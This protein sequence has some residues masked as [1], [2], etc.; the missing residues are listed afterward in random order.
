MLI[1]STVQ[2]NIACRN[3]PMLPK[4]CL[5][6]CPLLDE[7]WLLFEQNNESN[8]RNLV[9]S[10][11][12]G[13]AKVMSY[14]DI[15]EAQAKVIRGGYHAERKIWSEAQKLCACAG[16]GQKGRGK[17]RWKLP[18]MKLQQGGWKLLP[19][20]PCLIPFNSDQSPVIYQ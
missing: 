12:V 17:V 16:R 8:C 7:N 20:S 3:W 13:K 2:A 18:R 9:R 19:C 6:M 1:Y 15:I 5:L 14:G 11:M 10:T 4:N